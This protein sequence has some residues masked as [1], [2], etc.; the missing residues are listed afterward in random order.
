MYVTR[1]GLV[2]NYKTYP[3]SKIDFSVKFKKIVDYKRFRSWKRA[4]CLILTWMLAGKTAVLGFFQLTHWMKGPWE[5]KT[6]HKQHMH[7]K[8]CDHVVK[9]INT[10]Q[11]KRQCKLNKFCQRQCI[12]YSALTM[13]THKWWCPQIYGSHHMWVCTVQ[14]NY[15]N[16]IFNYPKMHCRYL[17]W[18]WIKI[19]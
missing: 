3:T 2:S 6:T 14:N 1:V 7:W 11:H 13:H 4:K 8:G 10:N 5:R 15:P 18:S 12:L 9:L 17:F 16:K 19:P